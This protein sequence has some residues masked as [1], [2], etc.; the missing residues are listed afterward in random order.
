MSAPKKVFYICF[1]REQRLVNTNSDIL[2]RSI[3]FLYKNVDILFKN[4]DFVCKSDINPASRIFR[5]LSVSLQFLLFVFGIC[6]GPIL[7]RFGYRV[8][9]STEEMSRG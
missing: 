9:F 7:V 1:L 4:I 2:N 6:V 5:L 3:D 8:A